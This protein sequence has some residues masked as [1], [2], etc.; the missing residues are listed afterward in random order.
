MG[1]IC[2]DEFTKKLYDSISLSTYNIKPI[3]KVKYVLDMQYRYFLDIFLT[4][5]DRNHFNLDYC[6]ILSTSYNYDDIFNKI[7][8]LESYL[9][10][11]FRIEL[12]FANKPD[13]EYKDTEA[14]NII[15]I[16][17]S[18]ITPLENF[19]NEALKFG[20]HYIPM[21]NYKLIMSGYLCEDNLSI[22]TRFVY[23]NIFLL[24]DSVE[25]ILVFQIFIYI[26]GISDLDIK[27]KQLLKLLNLIKY[28]QV[29]H[30]K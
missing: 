20:Y 18:S 7:K 16:H 10:S 27:V 1:N 23:E 3:T 2:N 5:N 12:K 26:T 8:L 25:M 14:Y 30:T 19:S 9:A 6:K 15:S 4:I 11:T 13:I 24:H 21:P 22:L 17:Y 29:R 28:L